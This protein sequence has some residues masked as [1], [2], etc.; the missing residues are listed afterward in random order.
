M[1]EDQAADSGEEAQASDQEKC[2]KQ[3]AL[4]AVVN[5]KCHSS[6][7]KESQFIAET[8]TRNTKSFEKV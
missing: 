3:S 1:A 2:T 5:A 8:A 4:T 6:Q 7:Q